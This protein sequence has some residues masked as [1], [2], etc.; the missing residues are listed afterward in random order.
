[1]KWEHVKTS[2]FLSYIL[3]HNPGAIGLSVDK[4]GWASVDELISCAVRNGRSLT[5][6]QL[7]DVIALNTK[8][9]FSL[10]PDG[11]RIRAN[12]GHSIYVELGLEPVTPPPVLYHGTAKQFVTSILRDGIRPSGRRYVHLSPNI[13]TA[14][15]VGKRHGTPI[16]VSIDSKQ[17]NEDGCKFYRPADGVYLVEDVPPEYLTPV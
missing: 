15:N 9:R 17:M 14:I 6:T 10:S 8:N 12:Y 13:A 11:H 2:K 3:R 1:M 7:K 16:V 5:L 4:E